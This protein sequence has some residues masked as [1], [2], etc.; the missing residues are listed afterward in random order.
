MCPVLMGHGTG[1]KIFRHTG[2]RITVEI[3]WVSSGEQRIGRNAIGDLWRDT[4]RHG[5]PVEERQ[6][7][8]RQSP[9]RIDLSSD[10][11]ISR[12]RAL[13]VYLPA[14]NRRVLPT[15]QFAL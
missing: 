15:P 6:D 12:P 2:D 8:R 9:A 5:K 11:V 14:A 10:P 1:P 3:L 7:D 4:R 13:S